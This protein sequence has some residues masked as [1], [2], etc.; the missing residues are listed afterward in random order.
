MSERQSSIRVRSKKNWNKV[1]SQM[2]QFVDNRPIRKLTQKIDY[3]TSDDLIHDI[4]NRDNMDLSALSRKQAPKPKKK[5]I[6]QLDTMEQDFNRISKTLSKQKAKED[7]KKLKRAKKTVLTI[8]E[9]TDSGK[10]RK[11]RREF[12]QNRPGSVKNLK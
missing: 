9:F 3:L 10:I 2:S 1:E 7:W 6:T 12:Y 5:D 4:E 8:R 11:E